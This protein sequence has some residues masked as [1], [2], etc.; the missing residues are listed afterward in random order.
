MERCNGREFLHTY[1]I[2]CDVMLSS[3]HVCFQGGGGG[4]FHVSEILFTLLCAPV[5][6]WTSPNMVQAHNDM[7]LHI[8]GVTALDIQGPISQRFAINCKFLNTQ[9]TIELRLI[10]IVQL[11]VTLCE[12]GHRSVSAIRLCHVGGQHHVS[13]NAFLIFVSSKMA[14]YLLILMSEIDLRK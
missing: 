10:S 7:H 6:P 1:I 4:V 9:L 11:I 14:F 12:L 13:E 2:L 8:V 5:S 3:I